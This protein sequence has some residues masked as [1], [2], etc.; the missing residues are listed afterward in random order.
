MT[1]PEDRSQSENNFFAERSG[2]E[3]KDIR[4]T[5]TLRLDNQGKITSK[6]N[7]QIQY[8]DESY[9]NAIVPIG[10]KFGKKKLKELL[11]ESFER[12]MRIEIVMN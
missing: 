9:A 12:Q 5:A 8:N 2:S 6:V 11:Q 10:Y 1:T 4:K 3:E 7:F